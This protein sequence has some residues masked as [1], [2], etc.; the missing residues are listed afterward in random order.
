MSE[1]KSSLGVQRQLRP[2]LDWRSARTWRV[3]VGLAI[4][5]GTAISIIVILFGTA[6]D[7]LIDD[8]LPRQLVKVI[9]GYPILCGL[10]VIGAMALRRAFP[11]RDTEGK[12]VAEQSIFS[13]GVPAFW[14]LLVIGW[15][16]SFLAVFTGAAILVRDLAGAF[17]EG[18]PY[19]EMSYTAILSLFVIDLPIRVLWRVPCQPEGSPSDE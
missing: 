10:G 14:P 11:L 17:T 13:V 7:R 6:V 4:V 9:F 12:I 3:F 18:F 15:A 16:L 2:V 8:N 5:L 1:A 19:L